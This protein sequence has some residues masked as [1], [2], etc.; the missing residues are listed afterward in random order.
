MDEWTEIRRKVLVEGVSKRSIRRDYKIG[1]EV[2]DKILINPEPPGYRMAEPR[3][4]P[5][6]GKF[7]DVI[8]EILEAD[9][10]APPKQ[11]HTGRRIFE[12]LRDE[13]G[14]GG[15]ITQVRVAVAQ[16]KR[17]SKEAFV[18]LSHPPGHAQF[19]FGEAVVEIAGVRRK[20]AL[21]VVTLPYSDTYFLSAYPRECTET[22]QAAHIAGFSFFGGVPI[23][24]S[25]DNT[26]I[27]VS[28]VMGRERVLTRAFL[29]L[30]SHYLFDHHFCRVG[31]GNE[32]GHSTSSRGFAEERRWRCAGATSTCGPPQRRSIAVLCPSNTGS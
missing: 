12:R 31:R 15:G 14:Y 18:P 6:L 19:D 17:Y 24:T 11:R 13:Y 29:A 16:A 7:L 8:D 1:S 10:E 9:K 21:G 22:F 28:R 32:K 25:Y 2:L 4:K 26:T 5:K 20:A 3:P 30:E 23:R 27:A